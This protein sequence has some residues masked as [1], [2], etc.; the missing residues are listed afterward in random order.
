M[1]RKRIDKQAIKRAVTRSAK[2]SAQLERRVVP[3]NYVRSPQLERYLAN[4]RKI[5]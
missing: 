3:D 5:V 2:D 4:K 1:V